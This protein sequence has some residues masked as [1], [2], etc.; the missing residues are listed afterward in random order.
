MRDI[1]LTLQIGKSNVLPWVRNS[2]ITHIILLKVNVLLLNIGSI[3][4]HITS[5]LRGHHHSVKTG[6][7]SPVG[8]V[9]ALQAAD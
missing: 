3:G 5:L 8:S 1:F 6:C 9:S 4:C 7:G 2:Y